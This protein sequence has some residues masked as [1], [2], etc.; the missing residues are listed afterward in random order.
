MLASPE[1]VVMLPAG[2]K[3]ETR[4]WENCEILNHFGGNKDN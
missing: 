4:H 2:D 1:K 3:T